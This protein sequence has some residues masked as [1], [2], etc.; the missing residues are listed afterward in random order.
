MD[1]GFGV[2]SII[3]AMGLIC[4]ASGAIY[5]RNKSPRG[6]I[7]PLL[8]NSGS[9]CGLP[10][11]TLFYV[12]AKNRANPDK[13]MSADMDVMISEVTYRIKKGLIFLCAT[14]V[15]DKLQQRNTV[16]TLYCYA[17]QV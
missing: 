4:L 16:A 15:E 11:E 1:I 6:S 17:L 12:P 13:S 7:L 2:F 5:Y 14:T 3:M 10:A 8:Y 9:E